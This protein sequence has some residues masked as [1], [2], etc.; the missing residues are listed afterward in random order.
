MNLNATQP[1][2]HFD[3]L[4]VKQICSIIFLVATSLSI[5]SGVQA[6]IGSSSHT[7]T[8]QVSTITALQVSSGVVNLNITGANVVAGQDQMTT[9][10]QTTSLLWGINSSMKKITV[11]TNLAAPLF[12]LK[13]LAVNPTVGT[14]AGEVTLSTVANN[15]LLNVGRSSGSCTLRYTGIALASQGTG[16]DSHMITF[17][18]QTQ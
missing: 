13:V 9:T 18:V 1:I 3:R 10:D 15:F 11:Q 14:A 6:Q 4:A 12:T 2:L 7:V 16:T 5:P 17:T 8:V